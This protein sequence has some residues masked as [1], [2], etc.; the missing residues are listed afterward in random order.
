[1]PALRRCLKRPE[2]YLGLIALAG[3]LTAADAMRAPER[4]ITARLYTGSVR[5]YQRSVSPLA[6]HVIRC[7]YVPTCSEYS[8]Q[9]VAKYGI[10]GG[11][12]LTLR[13]VARCRAGVPAG[14]RDP[15][16]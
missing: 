9:A 13:R 11:L 6:S 14:T 12:R 15:V 3:A 10:G 8:I 16:P 7:R 1:M 2:T 5:L 4:Q